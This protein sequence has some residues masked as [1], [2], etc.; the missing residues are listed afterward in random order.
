MRKIRVYS[1]VLAAAWLAAAPAWAGSDPVRPGE[2]GNGLGLVGPKVPDV[3][4]Q[5]KTDPYAQP[6]GEVCAA[7]R[8]E[9]AALDEVL[10]PDADATNAEKK[11][12]VDPKALITRTVRGM[13]PHRD[14]LRFVTGAGKKE[15]ELSDAA[16]AGWARRGYLKGLIRNSGCD[17]APAA[18]PSPATTAA[19]EPAPASQQA[20]SAPA[21]AQDAA[22][23]GPALSEPQAQA[24]SPASYPPQ[25]QADATPAAP[26]ATAAA[27]QAQEPVQAPAAVNP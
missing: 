5:A 17:G 12:L 4:K 27:V 1:G 23:A 21:A 22:A 26:P 24:A 6:G 11:P 20:A 7:A 16:M 3:L 10:G 25:G 19:A 15:K 8:Q 14:V 9:I 2:T 13:I 18:G